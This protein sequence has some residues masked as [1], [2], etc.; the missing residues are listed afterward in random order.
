MMRLAT[1]CFG[2]IAPS[3]ATWTMRVNARLSCC[4]LSENLRLL[5]ELHPEGEG[6]SGDKYR[7]TA[8]LHI[9]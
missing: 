9:L 5:L 4:K 7:H 6:L 2:E 8:V 3:I 1:R